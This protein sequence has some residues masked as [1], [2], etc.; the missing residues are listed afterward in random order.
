LEDGGSQAGWTDNSR[1]LGIANNNLQATRGSVTDIVCCCGHNGV[2]ANRE[3]G[4]KQQHQIGVASVVIG[5]WHGTCRLVIGDGWRHATVVSGSSTRIGDGSVVSVDNGI[6]K[7]FARA[8]GQDT[9][10][11]C[12]REAL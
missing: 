1:G 4:Y 12:S 8:A 11:T 6:Y 5:W 9:N 2:G 7:L 3:L 10:L